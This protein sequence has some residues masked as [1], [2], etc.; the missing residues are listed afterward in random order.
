MKKDKI[1]ELMIDVYGVTV[2][3]SAWLMVVTA[4]V[5]TVMSITYVIDRELVQSV[6]SAL[7]AGVLIYYSIILMKQVAIDR[8]G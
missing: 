2:F 3:V 7:I 4:L 8:G 1:K 6:T 5:L